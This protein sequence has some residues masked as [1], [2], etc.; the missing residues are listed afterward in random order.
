MV[1]RKRVINVNS[2]SDFFF[3]LDIIF[4]HPKCSCL[5]AW[6]S[7]SSV[8]QLCLI[9]FVWFIFVLNKNTKNS[10]FYLLYCI[11]ILVVLIYT[12]CQIF[13]GNISNELNNTLTVTIFRSKLSPGVLAH[14]YVNKRIRTFVMWIAL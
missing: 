12:F 11:N 13:Y 6:W 7:T 1:W 4:E 10:L 5:L 2:K 3:L 9:S 8:L 14:I